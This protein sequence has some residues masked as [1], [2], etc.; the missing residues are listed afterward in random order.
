MKLIYTL[1]LLASFIAVSGCSDSS[2]FDFENN[3]AEAAA[4]VDPPDVPFPSSL[5][6]GGSE[7]G[8][9]NIPLSADDNPEDFSN[10]LVALNTL[11]GFST[12]QPLTSNFSSPLDGATAIAG[13]T[14]RL[15]EVT[16]DAATGAVTGVIVRCRPRLTFPQL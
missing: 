12:T 1:P 11:D 14:V 13:D 5:L 6:F 10:P 15:F 7:D 9:L 4:N 16:T 8:T 3:I 2:N